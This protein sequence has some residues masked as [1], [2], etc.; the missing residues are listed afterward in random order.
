M[1]YPIFACWL[2]FMALGTS[3]SSAQSDWKT[4]RNADVQFRFLYPPDWIIGTPRGPDVRVTLFPPSDSPRANC[5]VVV[6]DVPETKSMSQASLNSEVSSMALTEEIWE[7]MMGMRS[8]WPDSR[9]VEFRRVMV[10]NQPALLSVTEHSHQTVDRNTYIKSSM[11]VTFTPGSMLFVGCAGKGDTLTQARKSFDHW[12]QTFQRMQ[13]SLVFES[14][15]NVADS[16]AGSPS[17]TQEISIIY[18][19]LALA[20]VLILAWTITHNIKKGSNKYPHSGSKSINMYCSQCESENQPAACF[21]QKCENSL[22]STPANEAGTASTDLH[23]SEAA[24]W[25]PNAAVNWSLIFTPA[26]GAYLQMLNWRALGESEKAASSQNWFYVSLGMLAIYALMGVFMDDSK[27]AVEGIRGLGFLFLIV[28]YFSSGRAQ[29]NYIKEKFGS[30]YIKKPW[31]KVLL[32]GVAA[33]FLFFI[34][35]VSAGILLGV[36]R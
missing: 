5:N 9:L 33:F 1:K 34:A 32:I 27:A 24:I 30:S 35:A 29:N 15:F 14:R 12:E 21:C 11:L 22:S 7:Q 28:W 25:N 18:A 31:G 4:Y 36:T 20:V 19:F 3:A 13:G 6:K 23:V 10:D 26:F 17:K 16:F 2:L 8:K